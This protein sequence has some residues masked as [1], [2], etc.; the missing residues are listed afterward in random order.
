MADSRA[1]VRSA[2]QADPSGASNFGARP[3]AV[4][5]AAG[6]YTS[7]HSIDTGGQL[8]PVPLIAGNDNRRSAVVYNPS[9]DPLDGATAGNTLWVGYDLSKPST[10]F[11]VEAGATFVH[12]NRGWLYCWT[13][14]GAGTVAYVADEVY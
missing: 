2:G 13:A 11:P 7:R 12:E 1:I 4:L 5:T 6:G 14:N 9:T 8:D 3:V 10:F